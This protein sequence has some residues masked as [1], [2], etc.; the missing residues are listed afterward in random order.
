[1]PIQ[2]RRT[3][4]GSG[5]SP[6]SPTANP[7]IAR[8]MVSSLSSGSAATP[9]SNTPLPRHSSGKSRSSTRHESK[10]KKHDGYRVLFLPTGD[11]GYQTYLLSDSDPQP[12]TGT[13]PPPLTSLSVSPRMQMA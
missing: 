11:R 2:A 13:G 9:G 6:A 4:G 7:S 12:N 1:M 3:G 10:S 8:P 5:D